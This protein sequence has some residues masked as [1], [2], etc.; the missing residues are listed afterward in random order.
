MLLECAALWLYILH[1]CFLGAPLSPSPG[2]LT[3]CSAVA[4]RYFSSHKLHG[5]VLAS[6]PKLYFQLLERRSIY[7]SLDLTAPSRG[8]IDMWDL[9]LLSTLR[10]AI[11]RKR[12]VCCFPPIPPLS[13]TEPKV[14]PQPALSPHQ[15]Q[16]SVLSIW[17]QPLKTIM[18]LLEK[19]GCNLV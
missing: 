10:G 9:R 8:Y 4:N 18:R 11:E 5:P 6:K 3:S 1:L 19:K 16:V 2:M 13:V 14:R 7:F 12:D 17:L 15:P